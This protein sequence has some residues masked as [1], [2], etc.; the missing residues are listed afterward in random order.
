MDSPAI[1]QRLEQFERICHQRGLPIT[2]QRRVILE[3]A[4][5]LDNHPT[6]DQVLEAVAK[7]VTGI[8]R[9]TVYRTLET[10]V[11]L[12]LITKACNPGG[13]T[14]YDRRTE[15]HHHLVC[16]HCDNVFDIDDER[17]DALAIPDTSDRGFKVYDHRVQLRGICEQCQKKEE[18]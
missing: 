15:V 7:R 17:F 12:G 4:L 16:L 5:T 13:V 14:R 11:R 10:L 3:A 8:S 18:G 2:V 9:T 1:R 6:A